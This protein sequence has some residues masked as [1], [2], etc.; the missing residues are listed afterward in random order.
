[1]FC[2]TFQNLIKSKF[3]LR[4]GIAL[5]SFSKPWNNIFYVVSRPMCRVENLQ[6]RSDFTLL[7]FG[8]ILILVLK[9]LILVLRS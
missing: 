9:I 6:R 7:L 5:L 2:S 8:E 4:K 1:M 3:P